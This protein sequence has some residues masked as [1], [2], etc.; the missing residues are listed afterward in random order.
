MR[1]RCKRC[2][3][4]W[5]RV[6]MILSLKKMSSFQP[7]SIKLTAEVL[8][9]R[10]DLES[11]VIQLMPAVQQMTNEL[12]LI[13]QHAKALVQ[14]RVFVEANRNFKIP[15][16]KP[17]IE[18]VDLPVGIHTTTCTT[19]NRTCHDNCAFQNNEDKAS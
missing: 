16:E 17:K 19:C 13:V 8:A 3:G 9:T 11:F 12:E 4:Q 18:K 7:V 14:N 2:I 1:S 15:I 5:V 10:A 6:S